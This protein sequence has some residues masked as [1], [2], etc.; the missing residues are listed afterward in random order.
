MTVAHVVAI[1]SET[2]PEALAPVV[3]ELARLARSA[4]AAHV[5]H[6]ANAAPSEFSGGAA[7]A[8]AA[9]FADEAALDAYLDDP[10]HIAAAQRLDGAA[11]TVID[12]KGTP[13]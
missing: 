6:G 7:L 10:A 4:G 12:L 11:V 3:E 13:A 5:H 9:V 8:L 1:G 2:D